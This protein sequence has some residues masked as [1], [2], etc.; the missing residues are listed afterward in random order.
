MSLNAKILITAAVVGFGILH[1]VGGT[2]LQRA[3]D[4]PATENAMLHN[5][6]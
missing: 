3:S 2:I 4:R 1:V 5:G 6:D